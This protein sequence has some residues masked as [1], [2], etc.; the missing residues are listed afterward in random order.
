[1][2]DEKGKIAKKE[3]ALRDGAAKRCVG[4]ALDA[5]FPGCAP[6]ASVDAL[7]GCAVRAA[8]CRFCRAFDAFDG[9]AMDCDALDDG[10]ANASCP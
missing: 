4:V 5:A 1:M 3:A 8:R 6:S 2:A 10:A 7:A 9:I